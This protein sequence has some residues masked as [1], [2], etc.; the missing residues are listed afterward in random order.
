MK[1]RNFRAKSY[2]V[3]LA[4]TTA[5]VMVGCA[6]GPYVSAE[7][8][9]P[10]LSTHDVKS[11]LTGESN[12]FEPGTSNLKTTSISFGAAAQ[13]GR[14]LQD[15]YNKALEDRS[16]LRQTSNLSTIWLGI[17]ALGMEATDNGGDT[18]LIS[19][20]V[21]S[22]LGISSRSLL[23]RNHEAAYS[24]GARQ[25]ACVLTSATNKRPATYNDILVHTEL[26]SLRADVEA[27]K[28]LSR[29]IIDSSKSNIGNLSNSLLNQN[30]AS[31]SSA[32]IEL[33]VIKPRIAT[34]TSEVSQVVNGVTTTR[35][36][37]T[38]EAQKAQVDLDEKNRDIEKLKMELM[39]IQFSASALENQHQDHKDRSADI[40]IKAERMIAIGEAFHTDY[41]RLGEQLLNKIE[42]IRW[43][44]NDAVRRSEPDLIQL[45]SNLR[46]VVSNQ[47][48]F[49][50]MSLTAPPEQNFAEDTQIEKSG[51]ND[52][53]P[54]NVPDEIADEW[55]ILTEE[56]DKIKA[57]VVALNKT[58]QELSQKPVLTFPDDTFA[59]CSNGGLQ[60]L[61][62]PAPVSLNP[63][64]ITL[65]KDY[66]G[67]A[68]L[69]AITGGTLP[70]GSPN[71]PNVEVTFTNN[72]ASITV[73]NDAG[74]PGKDPLQI[75]ISD[76]FG[77][78][79]ILTI[80]PSEKPPE[81]IV[82]PEVEALGNTSAIVVVSESVAAKKAAVTDIQKKIVGLKLGDSESWLEDLITKSTI[83]DLS[84]QASAGK[85][86]VDGD[87]GKV[88]RQVVQHYIK[89]NWDGNIEDVLASKAPNP[90]TSCSKSTDALNSKIVLTLDGTLYPPEQL[91][92]TS[93]M[94]I[95]PALIDFLLKC[96][97]IK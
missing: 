97:I 88:T 6:T 91:A 34:G 73:K 55:E 81:T 35:T 54:L 45:N 92:A 33:G 15:A 24:L 17:S 16:K 21:A 4:T 51:D 90:P 2:A 36:I 8:P 58:I 46:S 22:A 19:G 64:N 95:D 43:E 39:R 11:I 60:A 74:A 61:F 66:T 93:E 65:P 76:M 13:Y 41:N 27:Y 20:L 25:I 70:Y 84:A 31:I 69:T 5:L 85:G 44:V 89:E 72:I 10:G 32:E 42:E 14:F 38:A 57:R 77:K 56:G 87:F 59:A 47:L 26:M 1:I 18:A 9:R 53:G 82:A 3:G 50:N 83:P 48:G 68:V 80:T 30:I 12:A 67:G 79:A 40:I 28:A 75:V 96:D 94:T 37:L 29:K 49:S 62:A 78:S 52:F 86:F 63:A 7:I 71:K 23:T